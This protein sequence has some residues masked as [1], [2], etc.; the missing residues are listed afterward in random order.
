MSWKN[1][2]KQSKPKLYS[3]SLQDNAIL[4]PLLLWFLVAM[5][6]ANVGGSMY[7]P[8]LPLYLTS[9]GADVAQVGLFFTLS[10]IIPLALQILGGWI[11]DSLGRLRSIAIGSVAGVISYAILIL[12][13]S[14]QWVLL[15]EGLGAITVSLVAPS[16]GAFIAEQSSEQNRAR[17]FGISNTIFMVVSVIGPPL[18]G[19][20]AHRF[21]FRI[22]LI[23]AAL[24]YLLATG[25]RVIM[26]RYAAKNI[27]S[28][29]QP[30]TWQS[31]RSSM[32]TMASMLLAGG[33]VTWILLTDGIRDIGYAL[34]M[35]LLPIYLQEEGRLNLEQ[36]GMLEA[37]FGI[38]MMLTTLPA[39][40]LADQ[41]GERQAIVGGFFMQFVALLVFIESQ[42]I[43]G[44]ALA[45]AV[46]GVGVG[47]MAP[48]YEALISKAFP[49]KIRGIGFG[50]FQTSL[51]L[52]SLP[53]P[54]IGA[55]L[56]ERYGPHFPFR[57]TAY[58]TLLAILPVW[59]KFRL[60]KGERDFSNSRS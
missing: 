1:E 15:G 6:L 48:A 56:Y 13:P 14:W 9:L 3:Q 55:R 51:G 41:W 7:G 17:V 49:E 30:L 59:S 28:R 20:V 50:L 2:T 19:F 21:G 36:I 47:L 53:A 11:S 45:W 24:L 38:F 58:L 29:S 57:L 32:S 18:G 37:V 40:W 12:S 22:M 16:F 60:P 54:A 5:V 4:N 33:L 23:A 34:S 26:A 44:F 31:L 52:I 35:N 8:L 46:F 27:E 42:S 25:I 43:F 39:G 10:H